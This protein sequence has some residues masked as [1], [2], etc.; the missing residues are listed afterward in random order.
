MEVDAG[1]TWQDV[2]CNNCDSQWQDVYL[3]RE[4][5]DLQDGGREPTDPALPGYP[6]AEGK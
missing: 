1:S 5:N 6:M 4:I 3:L 2:A